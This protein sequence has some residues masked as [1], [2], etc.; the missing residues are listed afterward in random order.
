MTTAYKLLGQI[1]PNANTM[2][3]LYTTGAA[4]Q[5]IVG[6]ITIN[7]MNDA[8]AAYSLIVR[9]TAVAQSDTHYIIRGG[10]IPPRELV[11]INGAV[12]MN[13]SVLIA[14][15]TNSNNII[16]NAYGAEIT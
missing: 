6:T 16:F 12:A 10:V 3:N 11:T 2:T 1:T 13:A 9:P 4:T 8:N 15:N 7:N 14:A 5:A